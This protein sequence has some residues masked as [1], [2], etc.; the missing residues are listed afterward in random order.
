MVF[1]FNKSDQN[2]LVNDIIGGI[3]E[4]FLFC[5]RTHQNKGGNL[6]L[7]TPKPKPKYTSA[8]F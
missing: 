3:I 4:S 7:F 5:G 8:P 6:L 2:G 1:F